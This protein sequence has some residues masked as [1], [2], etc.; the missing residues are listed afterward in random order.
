MS[1][2]GNWENFNTFE[3]VA[4]DE[5]APNHTVVC[6]C[7]GKCNLYLCIEVELGPITCKGVLSLRRYRC[8]S[9]LLNLSEQFQL[10]LAK[11][12]QLLFSA[13]PQIHASCKD[14][15]LDSGTV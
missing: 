10:L 6:A 8:R 9:I 4:I 3:Q 2:V 1:R 5:I 14:Y 13:I 12:I 11:V 7:N 15:A